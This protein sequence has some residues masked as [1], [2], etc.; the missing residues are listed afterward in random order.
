M[1]PLYGGYSG[2][3]FLAFAS[4]VILYSGLVG[5]HDHVAVSPLW[6]KRQKCL[7]IHTRAALK[8]N[9]FVITKRKKYWSG[10]GWVSLLRSFHNGLWEPSMGTSHRLPNRYLGNGYPNRYESSNLINRITVV[11]NNRNNTGMVTSGFYIGFASRDQQK[12]TLSDS[13]YRVITLQIADSSSRQRGRPMDTRPQISD[14][15]IPTGSNI[16]SQVPQGCS[17]ARHTDWLSVVN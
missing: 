1:N 13:D 15:N 3:L 7:S 12:Y 14:S 16:W 6:L 9:F 17:I 11:T 10:H 5:T 2:K 8:N 4:A